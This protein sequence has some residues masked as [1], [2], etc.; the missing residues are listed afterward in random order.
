MITIYK[1]SHTAKFIERKQTVIHLSKFRFSKL[2]VITH[3]QKYP[4]T[5]VHV[6]Q[7]RWFFQL[8]H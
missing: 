8:M 4:Y 6:K 7:I 1:R 3:N 5:H 2:A